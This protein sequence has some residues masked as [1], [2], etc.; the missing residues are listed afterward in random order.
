MCYRHEVDFFPLNFPC[1]EP[2]IRSSKAFSIVQS[3]YQNFL[4]A[5][6]PWS[7][8]VRFSV[9][10]CHCTGMAKISQR[11]CG[12]LPG[13]ILAVKSKEDV[14]KRRFVT[15]AVPNWTRLQQSLTDKSK[16]GWEV[17]SDPPRCWGT[18]LPLLFNLIYNKYSF[19][20]LLQHKSLSNNPSSW[21]QSCN[22]QLDMNNWC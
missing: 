15:L 17:I 5:G 16:G 21:N 11:L 1:F 3:L 14:G 8:Q 13:T 9:G 20:T 18:A 10:C 7:L 4:L 12:N 6:C 22:N 2:S 19:L